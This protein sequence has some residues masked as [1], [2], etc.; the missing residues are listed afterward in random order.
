MPV[1]DLAH[2]PVLMVIPDSIF[3]PRGEMPRASQHRD[4]Q[5]YR[6]DRG[7]RPPLLVANQMNTPCET[8]HRGE[9]E[10]QN[11]ELTHTVAGRQ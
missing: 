1:D 9:Q 2:I 10:R 5:K 11:T 6:A 3:V 8:N 4:S 7:E